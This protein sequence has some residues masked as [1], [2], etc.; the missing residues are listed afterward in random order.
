MSV[1]CRIEGLHQPELAAAVRRR[2]RAWLAPLDE[3]WRVIVSPSAVPNSWTIRIERETGG[4]ATLFDAPADQ[5]LDQ[6]Q[7]HLRAVAGGGSDAA[8]PLLESYARAYAKAEVASAM[9]AS[10]APADVSVEQ[11]EPAEEIDRTALDAPP[12]ME[13]RRRPLRRKEAGLTAMA[14][15]IACVAVLVFGW[16]SLPVRPRSAP[17][18]MPVSTMSQR[19]PAPL[20]PQGSPAP[21]TMAST[22]L[23]QRSTVA[24]QVSAPP[25]RASTTSGSPASLPAS[26][27]PIVGDEA[28]TSPAAPPASAAPEWMSP[29]LTH[30]GLRPGWRGSAIAIGDTMLV[31]DLQQALAELW[32]NRVAPMNDVIFFGVN[33][34]ADLA[35]IA[36]LQAALRKGGVL[37]TFYR[38]GGRISTSNVAAT[39]RSAHLAPSKVIAFSPTLDAAA[40]I[41]SDVV[42]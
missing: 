17:A 33:D 40:F 23:P 15:A 19:S 12:P 29:R 14:A 20:A 37:W 18:P 4:E 8:S 21:L 38:K 39:A 35:R 22:P 30:L 7:E 42:K 10:P 34:D 2:A 28:R 16:R 41:A 25:R 11:P 13:R 5:I 26:R 31:R 36:T 27:S 3:L 1:E 32:V 6:L 24:A 9:P